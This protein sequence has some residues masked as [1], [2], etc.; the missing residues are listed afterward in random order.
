MALR[1]SPFR[2]PVTNA[3]GV[4]TPTKQTPMKGILRTPVKSS[5]DG[6]SSNLLHSPLSRT[7]KKSVTWSPS[8]RKCRVTE[9]N[10]A[11]KVPESPHTPSRTSQRLM[12]SLDT[13]CSP[14]KSTNTN[15]DIFKTHAK[16]N[17]QSPAKIPKSG[18]N[19]RSSDDSSHLKTPEKNIKLL[20]T[21][22]PES[23]AP[24]KYHTSSALRTPSP[25]HHMITRSG[26]TPGKNEVSPLKPAST[27]GGTSPCSVMSPARSLTRRRRSDQ[28]VRT[29]RNLRSQ[30]SENLIPGS[31]ESYSKDIEEEPSQTSE[32]DSGSQ[33]DSHQ[34]DSSHLNS[35]STDDESVDIVDAAVTKTQFTGGLKM[36]ISFARKPSQSSEEFV[37]SVVSAKPS[38]PTRGAPGR[39]YGFRQTPDRQQ[40]E[41]A[42]RL[43]YGNV[44]PRFST[45]RG[46]AGPRRQTESPNFL[47]YQVEMEMQTSGLPKLKIKRTDSTNAGDS[48]VVLR[49][50]QESPKALSSKQREPGCVSPSVC[51]HLTPAKSTPGKGV[52][53]F[54]CQSYTPTRHPRGTV[55]PVAVPEIIPMTPSPQSVGKMAPDN[56]NSWPRRKRAQTVVLGVKDRGQKAE[57]VL[58]E[59]LEE[60]ELGVRRLKDIEEMEELEDKTAPKQL[61]SHRADASPS[62]TEDFYWMEKSDCSEP[63]TAG[64]EVIRNVN[65][66]KS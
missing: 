45:P 3:T 6:P 2:S 63:Q 64:E 22:P 38:E 28:G 34:F 32:V 26:R 53:T 54:I 20:E 46:S 66:S 29:R 37:S 49:P 15:R 25:S 13:L 5:V 65:S 1:R 14:I 61:S 16:N 60:A 39:S 23:T 27:P 44:P 55:S 30:S 21:T 41:A 18:S 51:A 24:E 48:A 11:F 40:R 58:M 56:L 43:G 31:S 33:T 4:E 8:P 7:P 35:A 47:T 17:K 59:S 62:P 10:V 19:P 9:S 50:Q 12:K 36:N 52:Q 42:A 57:P